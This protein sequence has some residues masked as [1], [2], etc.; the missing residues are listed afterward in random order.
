MRKPCTFLVWGRCTEGYDEKG[1]LTFR[2]KRR[3]SESVHDQ[4]SAAEGVGRGERRFAWHRQ[5]VSGEG[6]K[7]LGF[8]I[9]ARRRG[10]SAKNGPF[11]SRVATSRQSEKKTGKIG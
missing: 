4:H 11:R 5:N 1:H 6:R 7:D 8:V 2:K 9:K 3:G 10:I